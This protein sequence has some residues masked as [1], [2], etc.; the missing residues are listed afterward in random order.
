MKRL[1]TRGLKRAIDI[2][3]ECGY[4]AKLIKQFLIVET[5]FVLAVSVQPV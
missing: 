4:L 2:D 3:P 1:L 5:M